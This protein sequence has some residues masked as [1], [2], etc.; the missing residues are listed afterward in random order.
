MQ[1]P[2]TCYYKTVAE[3]VAT[4][5]SK[6]GLT[7]KG[8]ILRLKEFC[9]MKG[10]K[11]N[12]SPLQLGSL[13]LL[14]Q[15]H[16]LGMVVIPSQLLF[17][18]GPLTEKERQTARQHPEEGYRIALYLEELSGIADLILKH[19]EYWDGSGYPLGLIKA[20][21][22]AECR[23]LAVVDAYNATT[24]DRPYRRAIREEDAVTELK[25]CAGSQFDPELVEVFCEIVERRPE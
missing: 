18:K 15:V 22:P 7:D 17:K 1:K 5:L 3:A 11:V 13:D 20:E 4:A 9:R 21:I 14:A 10:K 12:L 25:R 19:H 8:C 24:S 23:I 2:T 6:K 16:N